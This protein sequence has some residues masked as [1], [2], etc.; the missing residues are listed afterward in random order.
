MGQETVIAVLFLVVI[1]AAI[2]L[3]LDGLRT[4]IVTDDQVTVVENYTTNTTV[5]NTLLQAGIYIFNSESISD[6]TS[7]FTRDTNY[8]ITN[9]AVI[10]WITVNGNNSQV[11]VT[12]NT[13]PSSAAANATDNGLDLIGNVTNQFGTIGTLIGVGILIGVVFLFFRFTGRA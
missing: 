7:T 1:V 11:N 2:A 9:A 12:Y 4:S 5:T 8:S 6:A 3:A 13:Q 10:T